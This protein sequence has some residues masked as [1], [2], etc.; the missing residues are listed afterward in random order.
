MYSARLKNPE[1]LTRAAETL[2]NHFELFMAEL[3]LMESKARSAVTT[4]STSFSNEGTSPVV[5]LERILEM[6]EKIPAMRKEAERVLEDKK[7]VLESI[8]RLTVSNRSSVLRLQSLVPHGEST[9]GDGYMNEHYMV[10]RLTATSEMVAESFNDL[11]NSPNAEPYFDCSSLL[12]VSQTAAQEQ[13]HHKHDFSFSSDLDV[14][15]SSILSGSSVSNTTDVSESAYLKLPSSIRGRTSYESVNELF[16][17]IRSHFE[18]HSTSPP[19]TTKAL[20]N[21]GCKVTG[22][23]GQ[24]L[25]NI[26]RYLKVI[27]IDKKGVSLPQQ[28][29]RRTSRRQ[30]LV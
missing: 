12:T 5:L 10:G 19:L 23:T 22:H 28:G 2:K 4:S 26:L 13:G 30:T 24:T 3:E 7:K 9:M 1:E 20:T 14:S 8:Q 18:S 17:V 15:T 11:N 27:H 21:M 6:K 25:L 16:Q 29:K